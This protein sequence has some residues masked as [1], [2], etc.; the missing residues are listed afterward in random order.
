MSFGQANRD[1]TPVVAWHYLPTQ[2]IL[3]GGLL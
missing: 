1:I 3:C 2:D